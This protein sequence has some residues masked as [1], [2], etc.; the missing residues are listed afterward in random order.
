MEFSL[1]RRL[2]LF[3]VFATCAGVS[4]LFAQGCDLV[5]GFV[6]IN[7]D[8]TIHYVIT[9]DSIVYGYGDEKNRG[10]YPGRLQNKLPFAAINRIGRRG[11]TSHQLFSLYKKA[12]YKSNRVADEIA[13]ADVIIIEVGTN[14]RWLN[15]PVSF[16]LRNIRRLL[17]LLHGEFSTREGYQPF[18]SVTTLLPANRGYQQ[19]FIEEVNSVLLSKRSALNIAIR[20]DRLP[21]TILS[22]DNL[23]PNARGYSVMA[24]YA[25]RRITKALQKKIESSLE[26]QAGAT[27]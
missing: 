27:E 23:H 17:K 24:K 2:A 4:P 6:D 5:E 16:T 25:K 13:S 1:W 3:V 21:K 19:P 9:G 11:Y 8:G 7:C 12:F 20:F 10:G 22:E 26:N 18:V 14:D 15:Q